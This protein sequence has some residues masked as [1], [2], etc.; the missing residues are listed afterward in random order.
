MWW[1]RSTWF[2]AVWTCLI[3]L[4]LGVLTANWNCPPDGPCRTNKA[5][6]Y[7]TVVALWLVVCGLALMVRGRSFETRRPSVDWRAWFSRRDPQPAP[8]L[9][10]L[11]LSLMFA[12]LIGWGG[13]YMALQVPLSVAN[14]YPLETTIAAVAD[15]QLPGDRRW[16]TVSGSLLTATK[17]V[18]EYRRA[19]YYLYVLVDAE[20]RRSIV[21]RSD[22]WPAAPSIETTIT[23]R[24][25]G[26]GSDWAEWGGSNSEG[27]QLATD[28][29]IDEGSGEYPPVLDAAISVIT[30]ILALGIAT[31]SL[32]RFLFWV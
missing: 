1:R 22:Q 4:W 5:A 2:L 32:R 14:P 31:Y 24:V 11:V 27:V 3:F 19:T 10:S 26:M 6:S 21:V 7:A 30:L 29:Y 16:V 15:H 28:V 8:T 9:R 13:V 17:E 23:G 25:N 20:R 18:H 12:G